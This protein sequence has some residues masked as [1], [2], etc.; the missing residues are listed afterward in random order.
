MNKLIIMLL[1]VLPATASAQWQRIVDKIFDCHAVRFEYVSAEWDEYY[2]FW[3]NRPQNWDDWTNM[4]YTTSF[5]FQNGLPQAIKFVD[6]NGN[7]TTSICNGNDC[8][9]FCGGGDFANDGLIIYVDEV[10]KNCKFCV[11]P[12]MKGL[13]FGNSN[14]MYSEDGTLLFEGDSMDCFDED[15]NVK[16]PPYNYPNSR[17]KFVH[18]IFSDGSLYLGET[19]N[20]NWQG[21]GLFVW[22]TG[23][24]WFGEWKNGLRHGH[25]TLFF[26]DCT[27]QVGYWYGD[28]YYTTPQ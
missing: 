4:L 16:T 24:A 12:F 22:A 15:M 28:D 6:K 19:Y 20:G 25:G 5:D 10:F 3:D 2:G 18:K 9:L 13:P 26:N 27:M 11:G 1:V 8:Y 23:D 21:Y 14:R 7:Y 17:K